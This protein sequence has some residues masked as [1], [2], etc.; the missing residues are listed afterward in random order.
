VCFVTRKTFFI[1]RSVGADH[2]DTD[3]IGIPPLWQR[4]LVL[5]F[6]HELPPV[7]VVAV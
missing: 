3:D 7:V 5:L 1:R 6:V 4:W 2:D